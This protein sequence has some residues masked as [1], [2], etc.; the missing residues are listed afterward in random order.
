MIQGGRAAVFVALFGLAA[1]GCESVYHG[2]EL[3]KPPPSLLK[4]RGGDT[5]YGISR[6]LK[7]PMKALI[8]VNELKPPFKL[9]KG[10]LLKVPNRLSHRVQRGETLYSIARAY[11]VNLAS[12]AS[13]NGLRDPS[14][15][16]VGQV[17]YLPD[18]IILPGSAPKPAKKPTKK[19][20]GEAAEK[21]QVGAKA[22]P[23]TKDEVVTAGKRKPEV[24]AEPT[25][26][27]PPVPPSLK[28]LARGSAARTP[29][30][31]WPLRGKIVSGYGKK[32]NGLFNDG[33]NI[34]AKLGAPVRTAAAGRVVYAGNELRGYGNLLLIKHSGGWISA[35]AHNQ[36]LEVKKGE[37]VKVGQVVASVGNSGGV[38]SPQLHFELRKSSRSVNP[39]PHLPNL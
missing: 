23:Q 6:R 39:R 29:S 36:S 31:N 16:K 38:V 2:Y 30:F 26:S 37:E 27:H 4:V 10:Q 24:G 3:A 13:F 22:K 12:L 35:Y 34:Q 25:A 11:E 20:A 5:L 18:E 15:I 32:A 1:A 33:I 21:S 19:S 17:L 28:P 9:K 7:V 8:A 14:F